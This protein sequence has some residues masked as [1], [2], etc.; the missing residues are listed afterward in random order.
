[1]RRLAGGEQPGPTGLSVR[2]C[3]D[4]GLVSL[5][6]APWGGAAWSCVRAE[7]MRVECSCGRLIL[8]GGCEISRSL[9]STDRRSEEEIESRCDQ[10][11]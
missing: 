8:S 9:R 10:V 3:L 6:A 7:R 4:P 5:L 2:R 11:A 1:M